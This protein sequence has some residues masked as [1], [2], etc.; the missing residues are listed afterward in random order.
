MAFNRARFLIQLLGAQGALALAKASD[1]SEDLGDALVPRTIVAWLRSTDAYDGEIPGSERHCSFTKSEKGFTG[2]VEMETDFNYQFSNVPLTHVAGAVAVAMGIVSSNVSDEVRR[3]DLERLGKNV[4]LMVKSEQSKKVKVSAGQS[5]PEESS[6]GDAHGETSRQEIYQ[7]AENAK[8]AVCGGKGGKH[9]DR[10]VGGLVLKC[11]NANKELAK[12]AL[13]PGGGAGG[14]PGSGTTAGPTAPAA[15]TPPTATAPTPTTKQTVAKPAASA[16]PPGAPTTVKLA[17][18][19]IA[20]AC[21]VCGKRQFNGDKFVGCSCF[22]SLAK[23]VTVVGF[24]ADSADIKFGDGWD[25]AS[26]V[27]LLESLG[28]K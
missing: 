3:L 26:I 17:R 21:P 11:R 12:A 23:S 2:N 10:L 27:T 1:R 22:S 16:K 20:H 15:P 9:N 28:R 4:D 18:S 19:E 5:R 14:K 25:K 13:N 24:D 8:C 7:K 6:A